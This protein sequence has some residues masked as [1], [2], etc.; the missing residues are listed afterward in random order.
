MAKKN[1]A[2]L[3]SGIMGD[4]RAEPGSA[5]E[6]PN[7]SDQPHENT[8]SGNAIPEVGQR[9]K[10]GRP[11]SLGKADEI[12]ATIIVDS[13]LMRKIKYISLLEEKMIKEVMNDALYS[14]VSSWES[15]NGKIKLPSKKG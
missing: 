14:Y 13:G 8:T 12:H 11:R 7:M 5:V 9:R 6:T 1:L 3:M 4:T 2:S 15:I 10:P